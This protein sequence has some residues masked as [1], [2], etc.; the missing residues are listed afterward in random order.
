MLSDLGLGCKHLQQLNLSFCINVTNR[1][2]IKLAQGC[3]SLADLDIREC[4]LVTA[5]VVNRL[6]TA[7]FY[8]RR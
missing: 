2:L 1:G 3:P 4:S 6:Q 7:G 5:S 8:L